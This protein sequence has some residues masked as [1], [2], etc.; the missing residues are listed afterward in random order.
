MRTMLRGGDEVRSLL[1][2]ALEASGA[3][4]TEAALYSGRWALTRFA[5]SY[6]HQNMSSDNAVLNVR[7]VF[8]KRIASGS[9]N[10]L[11]DEGICKL[12]DD[13]VNMARLTDENPDFVSLPLPESDRGAL[14]AYSDATAASTPEQRADAV[15]RIV[16]EAGR[17]DGTAAGSYFVRIYEHGVMNTLGVDSY[18]DGTAANLVTVV[19]GPDGGFGY[20]SSS[21]SNI[22]DIDACAIGKEAAE[23][24]RASRNPS[25]I[26]PGE[27]EAILLPYAVCDMLNMLR[28]MGFGAMAYQENRSFISGKMGQK[29]VDERVN[30]WDDGY[31]LHTIP[32]PFDAE[33]ITKQHVDLIRGGV[34]SGVLYDSY[35]AHREGRKSTGHAYG[36]ESELSG[37]YANMVMKTGDASIEDMIANTKRGIMVTR[38]HY[39]N[40]S[41]LMSASIT[42]M[43]RDGTF[44]IENGKIT[45]PVKNLRFTQSITEALSN[46]DM[47]G[48]DAKMEDAVYAPALKVNRFRFSSATEF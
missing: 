12:V 33:G 21:A 16:D 47:I 41:H 5:N 10:R 39:T 22:E 17:V 42:G 9:T 13:V 26:E 32:A 28:Y 40:V 3:D 6:I 38:F 1:K 35:T 36:G 11:D 19:T 18:F 48:R 37:A 15:S 27:Y 44:L 45:R 20:A 4:Q 2:K 8:G 43:T 7:A 46:L 25:D 23:R 29:I 30:L 34:A 14:N 24:A 31:D